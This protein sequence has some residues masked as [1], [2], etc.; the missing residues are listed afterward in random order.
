MNSRKDLEIS[1]QNNKDLVTELMQQNKRLSLDAR[2][3]YLKD[4][5]EE[6]TQHLEQQKHSLHN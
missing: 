5:Q 2:I 6:F 4:K 3:E 1:L